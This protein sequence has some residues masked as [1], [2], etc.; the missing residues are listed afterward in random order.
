MFLANNSTLIASS[1]IVAFLYIVKACPFTYTYLHIRTFAR[2]ALSEGQ[3]YQGVEPWA[4]TTYNS[5]NCCGSDFLLRQKLYT[6]LPHTLP[7]PVLSQTRYTSQLHSRYT[8]PSHLI[9]IPI[10]HDHTLHSP[11]TLDTH[12]RATH[13]PHLLC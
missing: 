3:P 11:I 9:H 2:P 8:S 12:A 7:M 13:P 10:T 5:G 1:Q 6:M 4:R